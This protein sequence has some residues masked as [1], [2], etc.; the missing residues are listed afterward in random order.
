MLLIDM[1]AL[2]APLANTF[3]QSM[4]SH[5]HVHWKM[6]RIIMQW[7]NYCSNAP[8]PECLPTW[9]SSLK[10][11]A[12]PKPMLYRSG[13]ANPVIKNGLIIFRCHTACACVQVL[14]TSSLHGCRMVCMQA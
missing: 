7:S 5:F 3:M 11:L 12:L 6:M 1:S 9:Q 10:A 2:V 4:Q 14:D 13:T 8:E